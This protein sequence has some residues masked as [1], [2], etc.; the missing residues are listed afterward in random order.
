[1]KY[2]LGRSTVE[3][4]AVA[5]EAQITVQD[6]L[7]L[8]VGDVLPLERRVGQDMDLYIDDRLKFKVQ[9]GTLGRYLA[10][11]IV[12]LVEEGDADV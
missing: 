6:F 7:Q 5:G 2:W 4:T 1:L 9:A 8:Q 11:Q 3:I 12:S 10:V